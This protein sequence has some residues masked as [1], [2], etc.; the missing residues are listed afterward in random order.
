MT[1]LALD[2]SV[3]N[4]IVLHIDALM[5]SNDPETAEISS[6][7]HLPYHTMSY[8]IFSLEIDFQSKVNF[9]VIM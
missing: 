4:L 8:I 9:V 7:Y 5:I 2:R 6:S 1:P 3:V